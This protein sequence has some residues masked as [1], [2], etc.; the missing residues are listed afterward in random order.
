MF[1]K[2]Y[3]LLILSYLCPDQSKYICGVLIRS[4][5][6]CKMS[7]VI[8][9]FTTLPLRNPFTDTLWVMK[10]KIWVAQFSYVLV[11]LLCTLTDLLAHMY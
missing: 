6:N 11:L 9:F 10:L 7:S 2:Y 1:M 8:S 3:G 5:F 4:F